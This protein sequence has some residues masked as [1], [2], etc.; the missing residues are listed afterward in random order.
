MEESKRKR[1]A[2]YATAMKN[3][4]IARRE[5][6]SSYA[7]Q[8]QKLAELHEIEPKHR[9]TIKEM[10]S[11][12]EIVLETGLNGT[13]TI[14]KFMIDNDKSFEWKQDVS[15][16]KPGRGFAIALENHKDHVVVKSIIDNCIFKIY[17]HKCRE[18]KNR[19]LTGALTRL[20]LFVN[21]NTTINNQKAEIETLRSNLQAN[22]QKEDWRPRALE[23]AK[24]GKS[25]R[26]IADIV[27]KGK[28]TVGDFLKH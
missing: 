26:Q 11:M 4:N 16:G 21:I 19:S 9:A 7:K 22:I 13:N 18:F 2:D 8:V 10:T 12:V 25:I 17:N 6:E 3:L 5:Q 1:L 24:E 27:G 28:S 15:Q 14:A 23:L 20:S